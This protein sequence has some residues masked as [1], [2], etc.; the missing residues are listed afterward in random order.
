MMDNISCSLHRVEYYLK[1]S[2]YFLT[3][4]FSSTIEGVGERV[5]CLHCSDYDRTLTKFN[6]TKAR[7]HLTD[8][9]VGVNEEMREM[10][11]QS[12]QAAKKQKT[13]MG[14]AHATMDDVIT[15]PALP[16]TS[17]V[18]TTKEKKRKTISN[19]QSLVYLSFYLESTSIIVTAPVEKGEL[20][21]HLAFP[22]N[23]LN[24]KFNAET[25]LEGA[26][27]VIDGFMNKNE[28]SW[29]ASMRKVGAAE[30]LGTAGDYCQ[31]QLESVSRI[32]QVKQILKSLVMI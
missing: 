16:S 14:L 8:Q 1:C 25:N 4:F 20:I 28:G 31:W 26:A 17:L 32:D 10:F 15:M 19:R 12:T 11:R 29:S 30:N 3:C 22:R 7:N 18:M 5:I 27:V 6:A 9:C 21:L 24:L 13:E 2:H 23:Q